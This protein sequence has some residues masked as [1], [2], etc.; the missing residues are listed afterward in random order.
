[1]LDATDTKT[2][3]AVVTGRRG[4]GRRVDAQVKAIG[5]C[6]STTPRVTAITR[7]DERTG[8]RMTVARSRIE[9]NCFLTVRLSSTQIRD[10]I[11]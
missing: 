4:H 5:T 10:L 6:D 7:V 8:S 9:S 3:G 2:V 11:F 1:M